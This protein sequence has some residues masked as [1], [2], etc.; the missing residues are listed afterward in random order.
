MLKIIA[1]KYRSRVLN[2]PDNKITRPTMDKIRE[3]VFSSLNDRINNSTFLDLFAGSGA[4]GFEAL[5]RGAK[6]IYFNE[7]TNKTFDVLKSNMKLFS[8]DNEKCV[9]MKMDYATCLKN[10]QFNKIKFDIVY[11]DPPYVMKIHSKI[12]SELY[13]MELLNPSAIVICETL[14]ELTEV[15]HF[16]FKKYK[17]G[18]KFIYKYYLE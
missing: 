18:K 8:E 17:Y 10:L 14:D 11:L 3:A 7:C 15:E 9:L 13:E 6:K 4:I 12:V 1:G 5:S 2:V 16:T